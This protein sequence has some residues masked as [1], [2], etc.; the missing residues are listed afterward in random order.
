[1]TIHDDN[2][3]STELNQIGVDYTALTW[4]QSD[5]FC[6]TYYGSALATITDSTEETFEWVDG[7]IGN[8]TNFYT[9]KPNNSPTEEKCVSMHFNS[10]WNDDF[11]CNYPGCIGVSKS[12]NWPTA[13]L[14]C[15]DEFN[16]S[17]SGYDDSYPV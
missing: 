4:N 16:T 13:N 10:Q 11:V 1:M 5:L 17:L 14:F 2:N 8:Y 7:T 12:V 3:T 15:V 6:S 9:D